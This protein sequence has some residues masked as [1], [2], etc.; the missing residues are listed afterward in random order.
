MYSVPEKNVVGF[1]ILPRWKESGKEEEDKDS[2]N[3]E[4]FFFKIIMEK[5]NPAEKTE[6][7]IREIDQALVVLNFAKDP[8]YKNKRELRHSPY[9]YAIRKLP[10]LRILR[11]SFTGKASSPD[12]KEWQKQVKQ[13]FSNA[14]LQ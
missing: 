12:I 5:G 7:K 2:Q 3:H 1:S 10:Y 4:M 14:D 8:C 13:I 9:Q 11:K 6:D